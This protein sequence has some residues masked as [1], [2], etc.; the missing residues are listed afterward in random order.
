[1]ATNSTLNL[2]GVFTISDLTDLYVSGGTVNLVGTL[3]NTETTLGLNGTTG[4]WNLTGGTSRA[5]R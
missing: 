1:M 5:G 2:G 3:D 4:S